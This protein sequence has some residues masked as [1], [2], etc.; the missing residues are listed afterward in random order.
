MKNN[1]PMHAAAHGP[2]CLFP[3]RAAQQPERVGISSDSA[4][5]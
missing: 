4:R 2:A 5:A 1:D 3:Q